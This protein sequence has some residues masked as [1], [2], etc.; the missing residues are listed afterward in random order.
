MAYSKLLATCPRKLFF[1]LSPHKYHYCMHAEGVL[2]AWKK[3][4]IIKLK[5]RKVVI[6]KMDA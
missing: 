4:E 2:K 1:P 6:F 3:Y 5:N